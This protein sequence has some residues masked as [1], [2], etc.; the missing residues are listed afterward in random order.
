MFE[1]EDCNCGCA[2]NSKGIK[3]IVSLEKPVKAIYYDLDN[4]VIFHSKVIFAGLDYNNNIRF[5]EIEYTGINTFPD[6]SKNFLGY[7]F[8]DVLPNKELFEREIEALKQNPLF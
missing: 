4:D 2:S 5:V 3:Q 8:E 6:K 1:N 7:W